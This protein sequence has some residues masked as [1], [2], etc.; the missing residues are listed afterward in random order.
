MTI[1]E[2]IEQLNLI[3]TRFGSSLPIKFLDADM[4]YDIQFDDLLSMI[5]DRD[6]FP[7]VQIGFQ[8]F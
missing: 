8:K 1:A 7:E 3:A 4:G 6:G 2:A 5:G